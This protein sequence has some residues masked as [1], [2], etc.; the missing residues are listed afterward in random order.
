MSNIKN[1]TLDILKCHKVNGYKIIAYGAAA[2]GT[3]FLNYIFESSS[4][5]ECIPEFI[6]DDSYVK[7]NRYVPGINS[8]IKDINYLE[9]NL[10]EKIIIIIT[11]WNFYDE[12][13]NKILNYLNYIKCNVEVKCISFYP[14]I[15]EDIIK[16]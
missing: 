7:Q 4:N 11:A 16:L 6:I 14:E 9:S 15:K 2:K 5:N 13:Y 10:S 8:I 1:T 12:I 3:T